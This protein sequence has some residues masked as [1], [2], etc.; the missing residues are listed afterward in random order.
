MAIP[1]APPSSRTVSFKA[2]AT[3]CWSC[4]RDS[5]MAVV[6]GLIARPMPRPTSSRPGRIEKYPPSTD[7]ITA[8]RTRP[9]VNAD[10]PATRIRCVPT[11]RARIGATD[12]IGIITNAIGRSPAAERSAV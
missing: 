4:G 7:G 12:D 10:A 11:R 8:R 3:P 2:E 5:V 6:D 1:M 9:A